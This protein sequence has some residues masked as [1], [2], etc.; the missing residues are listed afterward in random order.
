MNRVVLA[1]VALLALA[2]LQPR[3][4]LA[5]VQ[6]ARTAQMLADPSRTPPSADAEWQPVA[7]PDL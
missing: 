2:W 6:E 1:F 7:L 3:L 5:Q 4:A